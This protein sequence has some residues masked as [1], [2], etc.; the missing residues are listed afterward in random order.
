[1][2]ILTK[3][4]QYNKD[5]KKLVSEQRK[6]QYINNRKKRITQQNIY[7]KKRRK[8][9]PLY[10]RRQNISHSLYLARKKIGV[11]KNG[12]SVF[13]ILGFTHEKFNQHLDTYL[14]KL[15]ERCMEI[16]ITNDNSQTDHIIP[17]KYAET[18]SEI[19]CLNQ[20]NNLRLI[21][22]PCNQEKSDNIEN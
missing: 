11:P 15:C 17:I 1:M 6:K 9:D 3:Q 18:E 2:T 20:L 14:N 19:K 22:K 7:K 13:K 16:I 21:C 10:R 12:Q 5:N 8:S 4:K